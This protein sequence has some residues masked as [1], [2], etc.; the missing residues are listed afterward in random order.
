MCRRAPRGT[1]GFYSRCAGIDTRHPAG[2]V[3]YGMK[4]RCRTAPA[5]FGAR[6]TAPDLRK[7]AVTCT[8]RHVTWRPSS[9]LTP[10]SRPVLVEASAVLD[11]EASADSFVLEVNTGNRQ[12][13]PWEAARSERI[14]PCV[15]ASPL[16]AHAPTSMH[17]QHAC[18]ARS[19]RDFARDFARAKC[20][21]AN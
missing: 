15:C 17:S 18:L 19:P 20:A 16:H 8:F 3:A 10:S 21:C 5:R 4:R 9:A 2:L 12:K 14:G 13:I 11:A 7:I 6:Q 1:V